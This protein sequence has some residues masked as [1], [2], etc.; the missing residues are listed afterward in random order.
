MAFDC[1]QEGVPVDVLPQ[2]LV[3][4][5]SAKANT[6]ETTNHWARDDP[7]FIVLFSLFLVLTSIAWGLAYSP[8]F[9]PILK[10]ILYTIVVD[11]F[12]VGLLVASIGYV[13]AT[14]LLTVRSARSTIN[15]AL[16]IGGHGSLEWQYCFDVHCNS[17]LAVWLLLYV[18]QFILLPL[19]IRDNWYYLPQRVLIEKGFPC[20]PG[21]LCIW[22]RLHTILSS[23]F[24]A[25][26][27]CKYYI[28]LIYSHTFSYSHRASAITNCN[29]FCPLYY[30]SIWIQHSKTCYCSI[31]RGL[32][33]EGSYSEV[34]KQNSHHFLDGL[35]GDS[36]NCVSDL[37]G[38]PA[39]QRN[40]T[41]SS[42]SHF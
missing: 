33:R 40:T 15:A 1:A 10:L 22:L 5:R 24:S 38:F 19:L 31:L 2:T 12:L 3:K 11:F 13:I 8:G 41:F 34:R 16:I 35:C 7:S 29:F 27:V 9:L 42:L 30:L 26:M 20:L 25:T 39:I 18:A 4:Q 28:M 6:T 32:M 17:F 36:L 37:K 21:I 14:K 23:P